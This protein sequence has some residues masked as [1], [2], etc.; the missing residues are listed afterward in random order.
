MGRRPAWPLGMP[1]HAEALAPARRHPAS[2]QRCLLGARG[3]LRCD[4]SH[5]W[6]DHRRSH[7][8][9]PGDLPRDRPRSRSARTERIVSSSFMP[10]LLPGGPDGTVVRRL[11]ARRSSATLPAMTE[12][13]GT[14]LGPRRVQQAFSGEVD[15]RRRRFVNPDSGFAVLDCSARDERVVLVGPIAHLE[16]RERVQVTGR[17]VRDPRYGLQLKVSEAH[18]LPPSGAEAAVAYL[19]RVRHIGRGEP[20]SCSSASGTTCSRRSTATRRRL[21]RRW[22]CGAGGPPRRVA[23]GTRCAR[24]AS[25]TC[26]SRR[27]G[28]RTSRR[29]STS[30]YG[31]G[32]HRV[33]RE[34]SVR[35]DERVR[36][37]LRGSPTG[38][39][40]RLGVPADEPA[41]ARA[42]RCCTCSAEAERDGST[43]LPAR[44][45]LGRRRGRAARPTSGPRRER[46]RRTRRRARRASWSTTTGRWVYRAET[47]AARGRAGA[48]A[49]RAA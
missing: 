10:A 45:M 19:R 7:A 27:T 11:R 33:V 5:Q 39:R 48:S 43:C 26:C 47:A 40:A 6:R 16:E 17:W 25:C 14:V 1:V 4:C 28:S 38:S 34:R 44:P 22:A 29:A 2:D 23:P 13:G 37:R 21:S 9:R 46:A 20:A 31:D 3:A 35:A 36:R 18:P 8:Q 41:R 32:A 24:C 30:E 42:R 49:C 12:H 15:V